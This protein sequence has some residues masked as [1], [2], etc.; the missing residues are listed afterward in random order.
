MTTHTTSI[1]PEPG[2]SARVTVRPSR[3]L[4]ALA[5]AE[6]NDLLNRTYVCCPPSVT[7]RQVD[8]TLGLKDSRELV[9]RIIA[10]IDADQADEGDACFSAGTVR[11]LVRRLLTGPR[12]RH[13][14]ACFAG[15]VPLSLE[16]VPASVFDNRLGHVLHLIPSHDGES[17]DAEV[18][19]PGYLDAILSAGERHLRCTLD[20]AGRV[21]EVFFPRTPALDATF[22]KLEKSDMATLTLTGSQEALDIIRQLATKMPGIS[23]QTSALPATNGASGVPITAPLGGDTAGMGGRRSHATRLTTAQLLALSGIRGSKPERGRR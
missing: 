22:G 17:C 11:R 2:R 8:V 14:C 4:S 16:G 9:R 3:P 13:A 20:A 6:I 21:A 19:L 5:L 18:E 10:I 1:T 15:P 23:E 12:V 7:D